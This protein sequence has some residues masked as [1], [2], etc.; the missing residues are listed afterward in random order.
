MRIINAT[1]TGSN[2]STPTFNLAGRDAYYRAFG[3]GEW[4]GKDIAVVAA[5]KDH[6][7]YVIGWAAGYI[8]GARPDIEEQIGRF[9]EEDRI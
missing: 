7:T 3:V 4:Y 1:M 5:S 9:I 2:N 6:D 8:R